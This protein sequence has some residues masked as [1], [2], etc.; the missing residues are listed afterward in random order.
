[1][2]RHLHTSWSL[3]TGFIFI[4]S[5]WF[6]EYRIAIIAQY[7]FIARSFQVQIDH[8]VERTAEN[9]WNGKYLE[10]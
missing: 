5:I 2:T 10:I 6:Y 7:F 4:S 1:M 9:T 8:E 3:Y